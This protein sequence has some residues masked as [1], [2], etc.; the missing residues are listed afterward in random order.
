[1]QCTDG[2]M[3][4]PAISKGLCGTAGHDTTDHQINRSQKYG[5]TKSAAPKVPAVQH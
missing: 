1:M 3:L 5:A 4:L 2:A